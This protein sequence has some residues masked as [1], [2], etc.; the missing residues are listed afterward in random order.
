MLQEFVKADSELNK[1]FVEKRRP[2]LAAAVNRNRNCPPTWMNPALIQSVGGVRN[3][4]VRQR[5]G[6]PRRGR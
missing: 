6:T 1:D 5:G 3:Q 2:D 4:V